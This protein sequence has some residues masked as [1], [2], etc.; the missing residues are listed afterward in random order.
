MPIKSNDF[1]RFNRAYRYGDGVFA[2]LRLF[3]G[4]PLFFPE[5]LAQVFK[6]AHKI[7]LNPPEKDILEAVKSFL[8]H[9]SIPKEGRLRI[10][11]SRAGKN[12]NSG[13]VDLGIECEEAN[14]YCQYAPL[15]L[16]FLYSFS[17]PLHPYSSIKTSNR[18]LQVMA[19]REAHE[20]GFDDALINGTQ[21]WAE[22]STSNIFF[23][24]NESLL[25][26]KPESGCYPGLMRKWVMEH[27]MQ[28]GISVKE[29][30]MAQPEIEKCEAA[31][32]CNSIIGVRAV[33][34]IGEVSFQKENALF[35]TLKTAL[36]KDAEQQ[37]LKTHQS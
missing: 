32:V 25:T 35:Y 30:F 11:L 10:Q 31:F 3:K 9:N 22:C 8:L 37:W 33:H 26:P 6:A 17:L 24:R 21:G 23:I 29:D 19:Q 1:P 15:R 14:D 12:P 5:Q 27:C 13:E 7:G 20:K 2:T 18:L 28:Q 36:L 34:S 4:I 16:M